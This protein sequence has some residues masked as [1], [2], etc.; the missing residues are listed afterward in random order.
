[1]A[2]N[3]VAWAN[4]SEHHAKFALNA[5]PSEWD[6]LLSLASDSGASHFNF[7]E[8]IVIEFVVVVLYLFSSGTVTIKFEP[9]FRI[10]GL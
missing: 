6:L 2:Y 7:C 5:Q 9:F 1:V 4:I 10:G 8:A 3:P